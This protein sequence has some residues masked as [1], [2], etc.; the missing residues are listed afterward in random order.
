MTLLNFGQHWK[1]SMSREE[2]ARCFVMAE[3]NLQ[4][5][6]EPI[7]QFDH[8]VGAWKNQASFRW[9]GVQLEMDRDAVAVF[10][11]QLEFKLAQAQDQYNDAKAALDAI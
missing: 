5:A 8:I 3:Q 10:K 1:A 7:N 6:Q 4:K 9:G 2:I 11:N